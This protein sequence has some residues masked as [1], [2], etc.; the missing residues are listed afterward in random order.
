MKAVW[1]LWTKPLSRERPSGWWASDKQHWLSWILSVETARRHYP[2][3]WLYTDDLGARILVD[4]LGLPFTHVSTELNALADHDPGWWAL[5]KIYT[6]HLQTGPFVHLDSDVFLWKRLPPHL[7]QA[8][9]LAQSPEYFIPGASCYRPECF[10]QTLQNATSGWLP[11]EWMWYRRMYWPQRAESCGILGGTH[12]DFI[13][14]YAD[15]SLRLIEHPANQYGWRH[16]EDKLGN[17]I[18]IEQYLLSACIE[19]HK[20]DPRSPFAGVGIQYLFNTPDDLF[21]PDCAAQ[22]G[23]THLIADAKRDPVLAQRL[24]LR[25]Q[26]DYPDLYERCLRLTEG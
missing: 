19:Y 22:V 7:E 1:S 5:G 16:F 20:A 2:E 25:V 23:Y 15:C 21:N 17:M 12:T 14:Y 13:R 3:T 9:V 4:G 11:E 18:L 26:R 24:E 10:E 6:Y 8:D